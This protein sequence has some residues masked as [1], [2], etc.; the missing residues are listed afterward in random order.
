MK[1][2]GIRGLTTAFLAAGIFVF[3]SPALYAQS[4]GSNSTSENFA[5][6]NGHIIKTGEKF[7]IR[8]DKSMNEN[9]YYDLNFF[10]GG[11]TPIEPSN[12]QY[13]LSKL[14]QAYLADPY[15]DEKYQE[16][17]A[18]CDSIEIQDQLDKNTRYRILITT[19]PLTVDSAKTLKGKLKWGCRYN[20]LKYM[21]KSPVSIITGIH[22]E[23]NSVNKPI[24]PAAYE[25]IC[26]LMMPG[27]SGWVEKINSDL[28][29]IHLMGG[30]AWVDGGVD[31][32][33]FRGYL[34][35]EN[36]KYVGRHM[37]YFDK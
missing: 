10:T 33:N 32:G 6:L 4:P 8:V 19:A 11:E 14:G 36:G 27:G 24:P 18:F 1:N 21:K 9:K 5:Q 25:D 17:N 16:P 31:N 12:S 22:F 34:V 37:D 15:N 30:H 26:D 35:I 13:L 3:L 7:K 29:F 28:V 2:L 20:P 23:I